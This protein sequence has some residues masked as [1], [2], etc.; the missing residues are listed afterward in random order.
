MMPDPTLP[1]YCRRRVNVALLL[2]SSLALPPALA[3]APQDRTGEQIYRQTCARC[4][5]ASGEG[6]KDDYPHPLAGK[7]SLEQLT[8]YVAKSM[9]ED[10]P[11][12]C[13]GED[14]KKVAAYIFEAFYSP[15]AQA[16]NKPA[17]VELSRLTVRQYRHAVADLLNGE[18]RGVSPAASHGLKGEYFKSRRFRNGE[19]VL[20]RVD[21]EVKFDFG[22]ASPVPGKL[23]DAQFSI[24]WNGSVLPPE[25]GEY[26]FIV[27]TEH[28]M[29]LWVNDLKRPLIDGLVQSGKDTEHR[30]SL[31]LL[32]GRIYPLRLEFSKAKQGVDDSKKK[33]PKP[34]KASITLEWKLPQRAV[35]VIPARCL[36][37]ERSAESFVVQTPFPPD[38]R[39]IGYERGT[40]ISKA[41]EQ[42][43]T[44]A[45]IEAAGYVL[46]HLRE[47]S[48]VSDGDKDRPARLRDFCRRFA[49][50]AFRRP[51][52]GDQIKLYIDRQFERAADPDVAVKRVV[53][54]V[55][56]SPRF[57]YREPLSQPARSASKGG[58][59]PLLA[60]RAGEHAYDVASRLS[61]GLWD[62]L[63][64]AELL[65][66]A[67]KGRLAT[68]EQ[69]AHQ[70]ERM[71]NDL[72]ARAK[73]REFL[74]Q[75]LKVDHVPELSKDP[76]R[77]P[78]FDRA[79]ASDLRT[80]LD[81]FL[82]DVIW[83]ESSDFRQLVLA[84]YLFLNGRLG[85][86]YG[87]D[88][89]PDAPFR[90]VS[91]EP[92]ERAGVLTH[93]YLTAAFSYTAESS[94]IHRGVFIARGVLGRSLRPPPEAF[95]PLPAELHPELTTR[96]RV[97]LQTKPQACV[98]CHALINPLGFTLEN[99]DA[100]GRFRDK[101]KG[102]LIDASGAYQTRTGEVVKFGGV[103]DLANFLAGSDET[104]E[105][106][107]EQLFHYLVKQPVRAYGDRKLADLRKRF[108]D[109][110]YNVRKL[111]VEIMA[112]SAL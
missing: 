62:S 51:L 103:R 98:T 92:R 96:D 26:E 102:R 55:L 16:R 5:G 24:R 34:T 76:T 99:Y 79:V 77:Y 35:E 69:V 89:P 94:P 75:W 6:T 97:A 84:D 28:A 72:R 61:F 12:T 39:S 48:G 42:A 17:R 71:L 31:Y 100:V 80:S 101:E 105:A 57:L 21:P 74:F 106:F 9:P 64:D 10:D 20:E 3:A 25:I 45:A 4:H 41:W 18:R 83:G 33:K 49:E 13:V 86:F 70:A 1:A 38:D 44:E 93:P 22:T 53:L 87:I 15:V 104:H 95:T 82:A 108:A 52:T 40:S 66:A 59:Q 43:T 30:A 78:G 8:R 23:D 54:L 47:L 90:K 65:E 63:P 111:M 37:P 56:K 85:R 107:I 91:R 29:R 110:H 19:R 109:N 73:L 112:A 46:G 11:G 14:A 58:S 7:R 36:L 50:R 2:A 60:L 32:G 68:R 27:R 67:A 81:L 88:V